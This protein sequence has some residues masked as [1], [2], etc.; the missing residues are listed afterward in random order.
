MAVQALCGK[1]TCIQ[2]QNQATPIESFDTSLVW[3]DLEKAAHN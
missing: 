2:C 1:T 3:Q